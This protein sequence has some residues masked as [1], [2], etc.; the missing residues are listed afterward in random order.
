MV[1]RIPAR[2]VQAIIPPLNSF[3]FLKVHENILFLLRF[4][5]EL[6]VC[7]QA[8]TRASRDLTIDQARRARLKLFILHG[9]AWHC[10]VVIIVFSRVLTLSRISR[11]DHLY[12]SNFII[13]FNSEL[14]PDV[15]SRARIRLAIRARDRRPTSRRT[16][17]SLVSRVGRFLASARLIGLI[18]WGR[19]SDNSDKYSMC[20]DIFIKLNEESETRRG[21]HVRLR[22]HSSTMR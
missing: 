10:I 21:A 8:Q 22:L 7:S 4:T 1:T 6:E 12:N 3:S 17:V 18:L 9:T 16:V 5:I 19:I 13:K 2:W 11:T 15:A 14:W 20:I